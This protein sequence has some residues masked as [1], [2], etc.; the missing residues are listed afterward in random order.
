MVNFKL[1]GW[2]TFVL[3]LICGGLFGYSSV[4]VMSNLKIAI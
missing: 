4:N 3:N 1:F 2:K